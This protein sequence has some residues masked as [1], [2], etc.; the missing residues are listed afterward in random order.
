[1]KKACT[2]VDQYTP[3]I[4]VDVCMLY[5]LACRGS[6]I[7]YEKE[8]RIAQICN[9]YTPDHERNKEATP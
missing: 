9:Y 7:P 5:E 3:C 2:F 6:F 4:H 1:M 8:D